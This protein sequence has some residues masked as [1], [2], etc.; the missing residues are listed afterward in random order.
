MNGDIGPIL[1]AIGGTSGITLLGVRLMI[2]GLYK[3]IDNLENRE[4]HCQTEIL[5]KFNHRISRIEGL[6]NGSKK[7]YNKS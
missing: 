2:S 7:G 5:P 1:A 4:Y 3:K 6:I